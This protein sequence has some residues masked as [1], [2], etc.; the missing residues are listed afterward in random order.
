M[1]YSKTSHIHSITQPPVS[2]R[3]NYL[4]DQF[5]LKH[6]SVSDLISKSHSLKYI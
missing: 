5:P 4:R 2:T 1:I 6:S 3:F